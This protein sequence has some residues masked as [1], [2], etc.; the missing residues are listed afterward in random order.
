MPVWRDIWNAVFG[1]VGMEAF[2]LHFFSPGL[3]VTAEYGGTPAA[4]GYLVPFGELMLNTK[5]IPC[6]MIFSV[7]TLQEFRGK[8]LGTAV[9]RRLVELSRELGFQVVVLC[10]SEDDLFEYYST[11]TELSDYFYVNETVFTNIPKTAETVLPTTVS[12]SEYKCIREYLL[13]DIVYIKHD[14]RTIEYQYELCKELGGGLFQVGDSCAVVERQSDSEVWVK[15]LLTPDR[16]VKDLASDPTVKQVM[17]SIAHL[18]PAEKYII[19]SPAND[20]NGRRFG[21]LAFSDSDHSG[22]DSSDFKP[23][24]GVAFD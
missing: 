3:C 10:P 8:G 12:V 22:Q 5:P 23:W 16:K 18:F 6:S 17:A 7:A 11:R 4:M 24:Y 9:V 15:E 19:R 21:M 14:I 13:K 2:F 20:D 1:S